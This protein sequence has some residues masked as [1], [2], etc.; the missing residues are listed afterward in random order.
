VGAV[1]R[2]I[3]IIAGV[4]FIAGVGIRLAACPAVLVFGLRAVSNAAVWSEWLRHVTTGLIAP[5][6]NW[7]Y[8]ALYLGTAL[9]AD[10]LI[11][12]G[13][14][15]W[16]IDYWLSGKLRASRLHSVR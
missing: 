13:S 2:V 15:R 6:G 8:G 14:G 11:N 12:T 1:L 7:G 3:E 10:D 4:S 9:L 16:S 5:H